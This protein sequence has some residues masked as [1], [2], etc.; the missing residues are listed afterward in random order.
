MRTFILPSKDT[1]IYQA[2]PY[3]NAGNDEILEVGKLETTGDYKAVRGLIHFSIDPATLPA[4]FSANLRLN[5]AS[6]SNLD[7]TQVLTAYPLSQSWDEG[8]SYFYQTP[9]NV[10]DGASWYSA[11][12]S[13]AWAATGSDYL[14]SVSG[15][16]SLVE[17]PLTDVIMDITD[18]V[19]AVSSSTIPNYGFLLKLDDA[20]EQSVTDKANCKF[21]GK[22]THTIFGPLIE[23]LVDNETYTTG[24]LKVLT[25]SSAEI[26]NTAMKTT[27]KVGEKDKITFLVRDKYPPKVFDTTQRY[28]GK[29]CLPQNTYYEIKDVAAQT[30]LY[31]ADAYSR[32]SCD[33]NGSYFILDTTYLFRNRVYAV[34]LKIDYGTEV[35]WIPVGEF[36][37]K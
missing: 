25:S 1:S 5:F 23:I 4:G 18:I 26:A 7:T 13:V 10:R 35:E 19:T 16:V 24:S 2:L 29:F 27:Y 20:T 34:S 11:S 32:V 12:T 36:R 6:A 28:R 17:H 8:T 14:T 37:V 22:Q 30:I 31:P 3:N 21:F 9:K 33:S 15:A